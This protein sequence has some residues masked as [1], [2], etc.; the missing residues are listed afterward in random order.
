MVRRWIAQPENKHA[1]LFVVGGEG[2]QS[3]DPSKP[4]TV[5]LSEAFNRPVYPMLSKLSER[6][7]VDAVPAIVAQE[8]ARLRIRYFDPEAR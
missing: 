8:G 1:D 5:E 2:L 6:F 4:A 7:G 3:R